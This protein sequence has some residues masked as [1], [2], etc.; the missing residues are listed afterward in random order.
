ME[1]HYVKR[2]MTYSEK[3]PKKRP[4]GRSG[5]FGANRDSPARPHP[6][7]RGPVVWRLR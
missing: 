4:G 3:A 2:K 6:W 7:K 5:D 1:C